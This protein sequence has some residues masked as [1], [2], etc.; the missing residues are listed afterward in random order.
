MV[1]KESEHGQV[2]TAWAFPQNVYLKM[3]ATI[4]CILVF[5]A[6]HGLCVMYLKPELSS[7]HPLIL[8]CFTPC[9][10]ASHPPASA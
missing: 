3:P 2:F 8:P 1:H 5:M 4:L 9:S 7:L 10:F 6:H